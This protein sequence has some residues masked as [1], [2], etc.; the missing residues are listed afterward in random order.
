MVAWEAKVEELCAKGE[1]EREGRAVPTLKKARQKVR[2]K[3]DNICRPERSVMRMED[4]VAKEAKVKEE[5]VDEVVEGEVEET[6]KDMVKEEV[7]EEVVEEKAVG[8]GHWL[9]AFLGAREAGPSTTC[10]ETPPS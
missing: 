8:A 10:H 4:I 2:E 3:D 9:R 5:V 7:E 6:A 1:E